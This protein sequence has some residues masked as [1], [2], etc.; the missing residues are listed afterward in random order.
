MHPHPSK[1]TRGGRP[2]CRTIAAFISLFWAF[3]AGTALAAPA[4]D[5]VREL[6][7]LIDR[8]RASPAPCR[9]GAAPLAALRVSPALAQAAALA[10]HSSGSDAL[11]GVLR[12]A[13]YAAARSTAI[14]LSGPTDAAAAL[15]MLATRHCA[16]LSNLSYADIGIAHAADR[17]RIVLAEPLLSS[18]LGTS[19][20]ASLRVLTLANAGRAVERRCGARRMPAAPPLRWSGLLSEVSLAHSRDMATRDTLSHNG[21]NGSRARQ[22]VVRRGYAARSVGENVA[23]GQGSAEQVVADWIASPGHCENLMFPAFTEMGAAYVVDL[24]SAAVI[25]WTQVFARPLR[26]TRSTPAPSNSATQAR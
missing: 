11:N 21:A 12:R 8:Q 18:S 25:Y 2:T 17:W 26:P 24:R 20:D 22:R 1:S 23:A 4:D 9:P 14:E 15:R 13:G 7:R 10:P 16:A 5:P 19:D 6:L 3:G